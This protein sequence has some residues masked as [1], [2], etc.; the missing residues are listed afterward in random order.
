MRQRTNARNQATEFGRCC[1]RGT[2]V[3]FLAILWP[4]ASNIL[5]RSPAC[6]NRISAA[7]GD[8]HLAEKPPRHG[9]AARV[10]QYGQTQG[11]AQASMPIRHGSGLPENFAISPPAQ[12][13]AQRSVAVPTMP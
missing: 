11:A 1:A 6:R 5:I 12:L 13:F 2:P 9:G 4:L 7:T 10:V 8:E 3:T